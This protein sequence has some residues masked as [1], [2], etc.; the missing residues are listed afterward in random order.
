MAV[1]NTSQIAGSTHDY[2]GE[3][4]LA[5]ILNSTYTSKSRLIFH[6]LLLFIHSSPIMFLETCPNAL[7]SRMHGELAT[8]VVDRFCIG[9][10][11]PAEHI[12]LV[13]AGQIS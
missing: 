2:L 4:T 13:V 3:P 9:F 11:V 12:I 1:A 8:A 7:Y 10:T 5:A 6:I